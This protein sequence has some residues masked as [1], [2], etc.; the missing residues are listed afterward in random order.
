MKT[1]RSTFVVAVPA[2][3]HPM[4]TGAPIAPR[5]RSHASTV[6]ASTVHASTVFPAVRASGGSSA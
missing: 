1:T 3:S 6:H 2:A 4:A 5:C